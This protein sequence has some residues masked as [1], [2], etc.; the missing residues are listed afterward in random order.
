[1]TPFDLDAAVAA[2]WDFTFRGQT[3]W[4]VGDLPLEMLAIGSRVAKLSE[5]DDLTGAVESIREFVRGVFRDPDEAERFFELRPGMSTVLALIRE[6]NRHATGGSLGEALRPS[7]SLNGDGEQLRP[8]SSV[9][10]ESTS[11]AP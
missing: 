2:D 4:V 11:T 5:S 10:T 7:D 9:T 6:T 1:V 3:F 8:T